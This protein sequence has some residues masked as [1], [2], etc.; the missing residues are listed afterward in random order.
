M[1]VRS[2]DGTELFFAMPVQG[3]FKVPQDTFRI[4]RHRKSSW[5]ALFRMILKSLFRT[6]LNY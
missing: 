4:R 2:H 5:I 1:Y 3:V 6:M